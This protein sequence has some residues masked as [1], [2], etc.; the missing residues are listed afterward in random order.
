MPRL[1]WEGEMETVLYRTSSTYPIKP[2]WPS[3]Y[4][5]AFYARDTLRGYG[6]ILAHV[7]LIYII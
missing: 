6:S 7:L 4:I 3:G 5:A 2:A 1:V